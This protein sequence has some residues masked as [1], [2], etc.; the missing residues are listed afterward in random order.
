LVG[1][2]SIAK[3][4]INALEKDKDVTLVSISDIRSPNNTIAYPFYLS[5]QEMLEKEDFSTVVVST[6]P[7]SHYEIVKASLQNKK[8]VIV[9]KPFSTRLSEL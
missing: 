4:W 8:N 3:F 9:E 7:S 5:F 6:P 2:G 1:L